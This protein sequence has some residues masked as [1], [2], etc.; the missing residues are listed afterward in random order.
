SG[1]MPTCC[2]SSNRRGEAEASTRGGAV[3]TRSPPQMKHTDQC[4]Q[5]PRRIEIDSNLIGEP[6]HQQFGTFVVQRSPAHVHRF[7]LSKARMPD[8]FVIAF[9]HHKVI[10]DD[11]AKW[12]ERH[13]N[14][15]A[16]PV[17]DRADLDVQTV[18]LYGQMKMVWP[19]TPGSRPEMVFLQ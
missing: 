19:G 18:F 17:R 14:C 3:T 12:R 2:N 9:A 8:R 5:A 7:D 4:E 10:P 11:A 16:L 1:T 6:L 15:L 13:D